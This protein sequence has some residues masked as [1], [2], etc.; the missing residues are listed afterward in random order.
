M[1]ERHLNL[2]LHPQRC[3]VKERLASL[4]DLRHIDT[5]MYML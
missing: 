2:H 1:T 5:T 4:P 3:E